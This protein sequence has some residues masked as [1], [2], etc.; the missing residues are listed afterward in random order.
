M[1]IVNDNSGLV[2]SAPGD[3]FAPPP[4]SADEVW[5]VEVVYLSSLAAVAARWV[6][7]GLWNSYPFG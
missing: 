2:P 4:P 6:S 1:S 3:D 7:E 5:T